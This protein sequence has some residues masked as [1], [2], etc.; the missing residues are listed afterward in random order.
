[1]KTMLLRH[2]HDANRLSWRELWR[3][4]EHSV[5][6]CASIL[7]AVSQVSQR[8]AHSYVAF[9]EIFNFFWCFFP[10]SIRVRQYAALRQKSQ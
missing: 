2:L 6:S 9:P 5:A 7:S 1:M 8:H 10:L 4:A 3:E